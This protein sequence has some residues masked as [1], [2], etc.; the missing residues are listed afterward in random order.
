MRLE[1]TP[2]QEAELR[3]GTGVEV[4][5]PGTQAAFVLIA[6]EQFDRVRHVFEAE[7]PDGGRL[8]AAVPPGVLRS[9]QAFWRDLP[10]LLRERRNHGRWV[11]YH[12]DERVGIAGSQ[13]ELIRE[14]LE[15]DLA[16]TETY[17]ADI[18]PRTSPPWEIEEVDLGGTEL[19]H[20]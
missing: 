12:R 2:E 4:V 13:T 6:R 1:L 11:C 5:E 19:D 17:V 16:E 10:E 8:D 15:R 9:Q 7:A 18:R 14:C 20:G 3:R